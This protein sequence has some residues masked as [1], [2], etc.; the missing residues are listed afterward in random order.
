MYYNGFR[1]KRINIS[2][3]E[4]L[5]VRA[6]RRIGEGSFSALMNELTK[7]WLVRDKERE[8]KRYLEEKGYEVTK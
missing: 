7:E 1:K 4:T 3:N 8:A 5:Y 2:M 6:R